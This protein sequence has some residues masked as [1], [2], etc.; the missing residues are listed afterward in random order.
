MNPCHHQILPGD[1]KGT[2]GV[3]SR[4]AGKCGGA[5]GEGDVTVEV[6]RTNVK[7]WHILK[8]F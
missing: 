8:L 2:V 6:M 1:G 7:S 3:H 5:A 4:K